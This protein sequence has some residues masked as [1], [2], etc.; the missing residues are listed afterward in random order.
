[1][2]DLGIYG[3]TFAPVHNG[4]VRAA[5]VFFEE[6]HLDRLLVVPSRKP[7]HKVLCPGDDPLQRLRML[8]LAF[9]GEEGIEVSDYELFS[10]EPGYTALTLRHFASPDRRLFLLVGTDM[11]ETLSTWYHP[12]VIFALSTVVHLRRTEPDA[13]ALAREAEL[14]AF[15]RETYRGQVVHLPVPALPLSSTG[16]R[17]AVREGKDIS[18]LVPPKVADYIGRMGLYR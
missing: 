15:Y 12:E 16:V 3:G 8:H 2:T 9:D 6:M 18:S 4:H 17:S 1:M 7:P 5:K 10:G 11:F 14:T 13:Q